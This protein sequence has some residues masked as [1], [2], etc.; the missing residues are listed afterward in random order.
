MKI[1]IG[2]LLI[3]FPVYLE[4]SCEVYLGDTAILKVNLEDKRDISDI[5][6][7]R[8]ES[9]DSKS[10]GTPIEIHKKGRYHGSHPEYPS[11]T[12]KKTKKKDEGF[13][14]CH[15]LFKGATEDAVYSNAIFLVVRAKSKNLSNMLKS[16][17]FLMLILHLV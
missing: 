10:L 9:P 17:A 5:K 16:S 12:I 2:S 4:D 8:K 13:Y 15:V 7:Y 3:N 11:L 6:W 1:N 14:S